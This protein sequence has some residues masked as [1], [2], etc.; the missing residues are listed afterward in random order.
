MG[1]PGVSSLVSVSVSPGRADFTIGTNDADFTSGG[2]FHA[3]GDNGVVAGNV[4]EV[5]CRR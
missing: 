3:N 4:G 2:P 1:S 5:W